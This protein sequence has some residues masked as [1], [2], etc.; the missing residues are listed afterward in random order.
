MKPVVL[1]MASILALACSVSLSGHA[2]PGKD[3]CDRF[4]PP[5]NPKACMGKAASP[6]LEAAMRA[7]ETPKCKYLRKKCTNTGQFCG[8]Y[9]DQCT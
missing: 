3:L 2:M 9:L 8:D 4:P 7:D 5:I 6:S 1:K